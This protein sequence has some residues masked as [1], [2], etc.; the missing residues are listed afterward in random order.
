M[1]IFLIVGIEPIII[2][3]LRNRDFESSSR[4]N[5][6]HRLSSIAAV[7]TR[8]QWKPSDSKKKPS[9]RL[10]HVYPFDLTK[11]TIIRFK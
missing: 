5:F 4:F 7:M 2:N 8:N 6:G 11:Y 9:A 3:H 10:T 1:M